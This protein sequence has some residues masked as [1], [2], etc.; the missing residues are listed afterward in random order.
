[1]IMRLK[2]RMKYLIQSMFFKRAD[3]LVVELEHVKQQL[4]SVLKIPANRIHVV[5]NCISSIYSDPSIWKS[6]DVPRPDGYLRLGY[7]GRNYLHKNTRIFPQIVSTLDRTYGIKA[8]FYVTFTEQEWDECT[9]EFRE[10]CF[11]VGVLS[12]VQCPKFYQ[13]MDA[14]V[15]P[16]LLECFSATPLEAMAMERPIFVSDRPFN[17]DICGCHAHYFDPLSPDTAAAAIANL[18]HDINSH[19][20]A[21][22]KGRE[23][24]I[25]YSNPKERAEK[26]LA[27]L[28]D[29]MSI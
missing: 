12:V 17:R 11:N 5:H 15:F 28:T 1:L 10:V 23:Y 13:A 6:V 26:Y 8:F 14:I 16:S 19:L 3:I 21:L 7:L 18:F 20:N 24:A 27:L 2:I 22:R 25:N 29:S 9:P 4:V